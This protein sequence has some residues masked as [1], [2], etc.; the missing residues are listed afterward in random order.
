MYFL[1]FACMCL[2]IGLYLF[3]SLTNTPMPP[4]LE[5]WSAGVFW[6]FLG[7][8]I[9]TSGRIIVDCTVLNLKKQ[10][11]AAHTWNGILIAVFNLMPTLGMSWFMLIQGYT[12]N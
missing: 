10:M 11:N 9:F 1:Q 4:R 5:I 2:F 8:G 12:G 6:V 3:Y 7:W